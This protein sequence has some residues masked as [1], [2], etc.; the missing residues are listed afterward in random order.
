[1][2]FRDQPAAEHLFGWNLIGATLG[3]VIEYT[4]MAGGYTFLA[5]LV[6][7]F[8]TCAFAF[9]FASRRADAPAGA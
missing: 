7:I 2:I 1:M 5:I 8:Y 3:G 6:A 9:L 4:S